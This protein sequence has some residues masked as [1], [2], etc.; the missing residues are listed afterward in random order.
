[1]CNARTSMSMYFMCTCMFVHTCVCIYNL[2][3]IFIC[4]YGFQKLLKA[5][6]MNLSSDVTVVRRTAATSI[7]S[8]CL[9]CRKPNV[10]LTYTLNTLIGKGFW[11]LITMYNYTN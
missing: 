1:M 2:I 7:L 9:H 3:L 11:Y 5:F 8:I 4:V 10:F 6:L